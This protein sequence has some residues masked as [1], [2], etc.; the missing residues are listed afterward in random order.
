MEE[1]VQSADAFEQFVLLSVVELATADE[2]PAHS[3]HV[4]QTAKAHLDDIKQDP[5]GG[6]ERR[7]V[8]SALGT[9]ADEGL[10]VDAQ[11]ETATGKGRPA[12]ELAAD[13]GDIIDALSD[14]DMLQP[15]IETIQL[16]TS[17]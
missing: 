15:Y 12:Y 16:E 13:P 17:S 6:I 2:T 8:I 14:T 1:R 5:F 7:E 11:A 4:T 10:L 3:Y 9:L